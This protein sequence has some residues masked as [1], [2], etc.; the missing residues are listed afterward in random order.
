MDA[1]FI[2]SRLIRKHR[3]ELWDK[4]VTI[5]SPSTQLH[6]R[7]D[8]W[9]MSSNV[10]MDMSAYEVKVD[11]QDFLNDKKWFSYKE[12]CNKMY[13]ICPKGIIEKQEIPG[14]IGL[15]Y[16][17]P[18]GNMKTIKPAIHRE[19]IPPVEFLHKMMIKHIAEFKKLHAFELKKDLTINEYISQDSSSD[20][21]GNYLKD[22]LIDENQTLKYKLNHA[23]DKLNDWSEIMHRYSPETVSTAI[24]LREESFDF[25]SLSIGL[26]RIKHL[27]DTY[28]GQMKRRKDL[29]LVVSP[30]AS[31]K[32]TLVNSALESYPV[33][34]KVKTSTT[35]DMR[36]GESV[37]EYNFTDVESFNKL[38]DDNALIE[39]A[40][41]Y[42][43]YYGVESTELFG[44]NHLH[45]ILVVDVQGADS[46]AAKY[47]D[48][49]DIHRIF[50][51]PP[52]KDLL[53]TRLSERNTSDDVVYRRIKEYESECEYM[54]HCEF[55]IEYDELYKMEIEFNNIIRGIITK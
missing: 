43:N 5:Y 19:Q 31:G 40:I 2:I 44:K 33:L 22:K 53:I 14:G 27:V 20:K 39:H 18:N 34:Y 6:H 54:T 51:K 13:F 9:S 3:T 32:T 45:N 11:R 41:V 47:S 12:F 1:N 17:Y 10:N 8:F 37:D 26:D 24:Q 30:S 29:I 50:I 25:K 7:I 42:G 16:V 28:V 55:N 52:S 46:I 36:S 35:R 21:L 15:I 48:D 49:F 38:I 4:E 23:E